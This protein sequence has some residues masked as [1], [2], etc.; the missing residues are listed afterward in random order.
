[1]NADGLLTL[2]CDDARHPAK[3]P[4]VFIAKLSR[5]NVG[6]LPEQNPYKGKGNL[7]SHKGGVAIEWLR[8]DALLGPAAWSG[9]RVIWHGRDDQGPDGASDRLRVRITCRYCKEPWVLRAGKLD[10][11]LDQVVDTG[12]AYV[13]LTELRRILNTSGSL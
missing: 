9:D 8:D 1:M 2:F 5:A 3:R 12:R 6:W 10:A 13:T 7:Y 11:A 4:R